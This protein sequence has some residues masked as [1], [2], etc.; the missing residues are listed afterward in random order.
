MPLTRNLTNLSWYLDTNVIDRPEFTDLGRMY[1]LGWIYLQAPDTVLKELSTAKD[2]DKRKTLLD[3]LAKFPI[4]M[5][6][7]VSGHSLPGFSVSNLEIDQ[8]RLENVHRII[9]NGKTFQSDTAQSDLGNRKA[10]SRL[11]DSMIV[12]TTIRYAHKALITEDSGLI[13]A[14]NALSVEFQGFQIITI[15]QATAPALSKIARVRKFR[16]LEPGNQW[17]QD[18]PEW[19]S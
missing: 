13:A 17:V 19:P 8:A 11:R 15:R 14:S 7:S 18:L 12:A 3:L 2:I 1:R 6:P 4:A 16:E 9:W 10:S 5:G